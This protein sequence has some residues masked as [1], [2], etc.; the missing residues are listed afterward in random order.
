MTTVYNEAGLR[1]E[2]DQDSV[3]LYIYDDHV[4]TM[5]T[6]DFMR[7]AIALVDG[8]IVKIMPT[9]DKEYCG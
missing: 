1:A 5:T 3:S 7:I 2:A 9:Q 8:D 4:T 6:G